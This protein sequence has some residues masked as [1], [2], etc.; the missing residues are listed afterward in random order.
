MEFLHKNTRTFYNTL[1]PFT[2]VYC[3]D[4]DDYLDRIVSDR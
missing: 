2:S 4:Y 3:Q 1:L